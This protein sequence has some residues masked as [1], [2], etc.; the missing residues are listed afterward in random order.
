MELSRELGQFFTPAE[1][2]DLAFGVLAWL[3]PTVAKGKLLD[4]SCGEGA[5]LL[6]AL[7]AGFAVGNLYGI[8]ADARLPQV[9]RENG[10]GQQSRLNLAVAN[11]LLG[12]GEGLFDVV[13]GNPPF[14]GG[15]EQEHDHLASAY[16]WWRLGQRKAPG[17]PRELWFLERSLKLLRPEGLLAMV[18]PEGFLANRRWRWQRQE[19]LSLYQVE[20]II[21]LPRNLFRSSRT[22][23]KT[24]LLFVRHRSPAAGHRVRLAELETSELAEALPMLLKHW[25]TGRPLAEAHPWKG[26]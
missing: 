17:F 16:G 1:A 9:W 23:V 6:G 26:R 5:F 18:L 3:Q 15:A 8:D 10:L 22:N 12:G 14:G 11:G 13:V 20:A 2:V 24:S 21:G 19:L 25:Q 4:L 7:R